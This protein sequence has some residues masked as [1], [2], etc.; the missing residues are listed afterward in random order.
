MASGLADWKDLLVLALYF[1]FVL[2]VGIM[3]SRHYIFRL[4]YMLSFICRL[5][6]QRIIRDVFLF[7]TQSKSEIMRKFSW[8]NSEESGN[9]IV[10]IR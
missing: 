2:V 8:Y 10:L 6:H 9:L 5:N 4:T 1:A 3:V 7:F